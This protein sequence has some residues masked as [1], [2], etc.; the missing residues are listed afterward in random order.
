MENLW[1][2]QEAEIEHA[3]DPA[4]ALFWDCRT[5]KTRAIIGQIEKLIEHGVKRFLIIAPK[6]VCSEVWW[7]EFWELTKLHVMDLSQGSLQSRLIQL[8]SLEQ[9][10]HPMIV[11][12]NWDVIAKKEILNELLKWGPE[13]VVADE[14]H[15]AMSAGSAR[16][17]AL[18]R[19]GGRA[20][21]RRGLTGTPTPKNYIDAYSQYKFLDSS[22]FGTNKARFLERYVD[23]DFWGRPKNYLHLTELRQKM[24]SIGSRVDRHMVW[25]DRA[26]LE[27]TRKA[28]LPEKA[29]KLYD[30]IVKEC[31]AE[32]DGVTID[33]THKLV[34]ITKLQ[35]LTAGFVHE[36]ETVKWV[37]TTKV[38][39]VL[40]EIKDLLASDEKV[41]IFYHF[42]PEGEKYLEEIRKQFGPVAG[43]INGKTPMNM[44][45]TLSEQFAK[46]DS[47]M[48]IMIMQDSLG[49]GISL[50]S[51]SYVI[52]TSYPLDYAAFTQSN[53][54]IYEPG[55]PLTYI[56]IDSPRT[57]DQFARSI[58]VNKHSASQRLLNVGFESALKGY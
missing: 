4:R 5:G 38:D 8:H 17:R 49:I 53:D 3:L 27:I 16:S 41:V 13:V 19:L 32:Y 36:G 21:F 40:T 54:R 34:Q 48:R 10:Q 43:L 28:P 45:K 25:K 22:I 15:Y 50:K 55:K 24:F 29:R 6:L 12:I 33:A 51:A 26:P 37:H 57:V 23:L 44:R 18:H 9:I 52:R 20:R 31:L 7:N 42:T 11:L 14:L 30:K 56:Y 47:D 58:V 35:Q 39:T 2:W 1:Q 46:P